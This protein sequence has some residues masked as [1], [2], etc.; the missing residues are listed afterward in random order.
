MTPVQLVSVDSSIV[1]SYDRAGKTGG[2]RQSLRPLSELKF[3]VAPRE[4][5]D[6]LLALHGAVQSA[7]GDLRITELHRDVKTQQAAREKY[8]AWVRAQK[9]KPGSAGFNAGT[10]K[11]AFV[12]LP[13]RSMHNGGRAIDFHVDALKFPG[14]PA[15]RQLDRMWE[16]AIPLGWAPVIKSPTEGASE[17]W[18]MDYWGELRE[19]RDRLGYEQAA[20]CGA[21]LVGHGALSGYAPT[22]QAILVRGGYVI[23]NIDGEIGPRTRGAVEVALNLGREEV[24]SRL[25]RKDESLIAALMEVRRLPAG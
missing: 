16:I 14:V 23:G 13:G 25:D 6:A 11:A 10:M 20:L 3:G 15:D 5:A 22:I 4:V 24:K 19:V 7:G 12:T 21:I 8:D 18:H 9:P 2:P 17:S 1:S